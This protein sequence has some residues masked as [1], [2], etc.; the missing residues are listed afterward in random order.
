M[1]AAWGLGMS[2]LAAGFVPGNPVQVATMAFTALVGYGVVQLIVSLV[3][4]VRE[5]NRR[6]KRPTRRNG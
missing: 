6:G 2:A 3:M 4:S 5:V 1:L